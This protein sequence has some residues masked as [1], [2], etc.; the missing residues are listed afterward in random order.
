MNARLNAWL[1]K[2]LILNIEQGMKIKEE[3][4][5]TRFQD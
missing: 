2:K 4:K 1:K 3:E 5:I